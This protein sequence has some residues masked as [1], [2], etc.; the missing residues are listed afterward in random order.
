MT[1]TTVGQKHELRVESLSSPAGERAILN[2]E[3]QN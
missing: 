1:G 3:N 2:I